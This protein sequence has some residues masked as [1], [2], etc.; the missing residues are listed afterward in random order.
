MN[1]LSAQ[2][3]Q[4]VARIIARHQLKPVC[5]NEQ[6]TL[7]ATTPGLLRLQQKHHHAGLCLWAEQAGV[8]SHRIQ[9]SATAE[10]VD[11][12]GS[13]REQ[14]QEQQQQQHGEQQQQQQQPTSVCR[15]LAGRN[16]TAA[17]A[18]NGNT[19][20][21]TS[22]VTANASSSSS[23]RCVYHYLQVGELP[24]RSIHGHNSTPQLLETPKQG[25]L[26][27]LRF[28][29]Q[30]L[31]LPQQQKVDVVLEMDLQACSRTQKHEVCD[32][33]VAGGWWLFSRIAYNCVL[34]YNSQLEASLV[35]SNSIST[36]P[37]A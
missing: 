15:E 1:G 37:L 26:V 5:K 11:G 19:D 17:D 16:A 6:E 9:S 8:A 28:S 29:H 32:S 20:S 25:Q 3:H 4:A 7:W 27:H 33:V 35:A 34:L 10:P 13:S 2:Q 24:S 22:T 18:T 36:Q 14:Q 12:M 21:P 23:S 31:Q 30:G